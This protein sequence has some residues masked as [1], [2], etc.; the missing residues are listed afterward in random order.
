M[1]TTQQKGLSSYYKTKIEEL[2]LVINDKTQNLRRL[3]AQRNQLNAKGC[4]YFP[5]LPLKF[6]LIPI[7]IVVTSSFLIMA[8]I[9][10]IFDI[11]IFN[12]YCNYKLYIILIFAFIILNS[13]RAYFYFALKLYWNVILID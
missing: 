1:A 2:E 6:D 11:L 7:F 10:F 13:R 8:L 4:T 12:V 3:E 5:G 9:F